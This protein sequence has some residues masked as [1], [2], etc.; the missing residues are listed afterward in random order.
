MAHYRLVADI[1]GYNQNLQEGFDAVEGR[2]YDESNKCVGGYL[3]TNL[4]WL[5]SDLLRIANFNPKKDTFE[6][7]W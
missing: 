4:E 3:S 7:N 5:E 1:E 2:I 6:K